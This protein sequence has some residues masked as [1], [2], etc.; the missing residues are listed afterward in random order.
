MPDM[1]IDW[2][3]KLDKSDVG[4]ED[5]V[6]FVYLKAL[7][8]LAKEAG[9]R[10]ELHTLG[11]VILLKSKDGTESPFV[12]VQYTSKWADGTVYSDVA[13]AHIHNTNDIFQMYLSSIAANRAEARAIRK[14]LGISMVAKEELGAKKGA[15]YDMTGPIS[16]EQLAGIKMM[17]K[18][19]GIRDIGDILKEATKRADIISLEELNFKEGQEAMKFLNSR[20]AS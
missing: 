9:L 8:R 10:E 13:D 6:K 17:M 1:K 4:E 19:T 14:A 5:G 18:K 7:R 20:V 16:K 2:N 15:N 3:A 11:N 12:Q